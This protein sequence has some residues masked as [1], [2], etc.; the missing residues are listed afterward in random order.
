TQ[1]RTRARR[2]VCISISCGCYQPTGSVYRQPLPSSYR[3]PVYR[4]QPDTAPC[5]TNCM[6]GCMQ[7]QQNTC[8]QSCQNLCS[9]QPTYQQ[10]K[11]YAPV[12]YQYE[13]ST[14]DI[15]TGQQSAIGQQSATGTCLHV[16]MPSCESQCIQRS[17]PAPAISQHNNPVP[18]V[19]SQ[20]PSYYPVQQY[21]PAMQ[22][23]A[24]SD[25]TI[26]VHLCMPS[27]EKQCIERTIS[28]IPSHPERSEQPNGIYY[29][30]PTPDSSVSYQNFIP[31]NQTSII[32]RPL[33]N[34]GTATIC[35]PICTGPCPTECT[36]SQK[37]SGAG[38]EYTNGGTT[39][40][41]ITPTQTDLLPREISISLPQSIQQSPD[42]MNLCHE[43]CMQQ[44]IEQNQPADQ[45]QPSCSYT[46]HESC[47]HSPVNTATISS[48]QQPQIETEIYETVAPIPDNSM[49]SPLF[50][51]FLLRSP[52]Y[53]RQNS[54]YEPQVINCL[55]GSA[56][57][58]QCKCPSGYV[59]CLSTQSR[60][61]KQQCCRRR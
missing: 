19:K 28:A 22:Q 1:L 33:P 44:C 49:N 43:T 56:R 13:P 60:I 61:S 24:N 11:G 25:N 59:V 9:T 18:V 15:A 40:E 21:E 38:D 32:I 58:G 8:Q 55:F 4:Q 10:S 42:C 31:A 12:S 26:C 23:Y 2:C 51:T 17:T 54:I 52:P 37:Q 5:V 35:L 45:C 7:K 48:I 53:Y 30:K 46:C 50:K 16:C 20:T 39:Q 29:P 6:Q 3:Q 34:S 14:S 41:P 36:E 47:A 27:C 57:S